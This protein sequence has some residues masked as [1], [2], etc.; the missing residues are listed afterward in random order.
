MLERELI[1]R[2]SFVNILP[3][4]NLIKFYS[5]PFRVFVDAIVGVDGDL[6]NPSV[7]GEYP[8]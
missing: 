5:P 7:K 3:E 8:F 2:K 6:C 1:I 4:N